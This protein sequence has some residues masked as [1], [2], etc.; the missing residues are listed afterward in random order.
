VSVDEGGGL[1]PAANRKD[2]TE[3]A[4]E[5][6]SSAAVLKNSRLSLRLFSFS[7]GFRI[8]KSRPCGDR[9]GKE[10]CLFNELEQTIHRR[11]TERGRK[12]MTIR[13]TRL[14]GEES[15][16]RYQF[17]SDPSHGSLDGWPRGRAYGRE[18]RRGVT[19]HREEASRREAEERGEE[20]RLG[21]MKLSREKSKELFFALVSELE[22]E[23]SRLWW[24][25]EGWVGGPGR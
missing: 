2:G 8:F 4:D 21:D 24:I 25:R 14:N 19:W 3:Q 7:T 1:G 22:T 11:E 18:E 17:V 16:E 6:R 23:I 20:H 9:E 12:E 13:Q 5:V 10:I 15:F